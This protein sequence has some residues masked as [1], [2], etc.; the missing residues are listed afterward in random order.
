MSD[1]L[2]KREIKESVD[3][4]SKDKKKQSKSIWYVVM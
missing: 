1:K 2:T 4:R 3:R